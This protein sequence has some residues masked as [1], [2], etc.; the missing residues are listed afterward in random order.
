LENVQL[1]KIALGS[2]LEGPSSDQLSPL[3]TQILPTL[4]QRLTT[5][6]HSHV[7]DTSAW[8]VGK[9][10][11]LQGDCIHDNQLEMLTTSL[12][13]G[14]MDD[15]KIAANCAWVTFP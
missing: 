2:I 3:T 12:L 5:D 1:I 8:T 6:A 4:L 10:C 13:R 14:L 15:P 9:I 11:E 7:K